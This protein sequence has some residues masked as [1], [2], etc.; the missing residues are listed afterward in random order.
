MNKVCNKCQQEI[1]I[2]R[3]TEHYIKA[4]IDPNYKLKNI[5]YYKINNPTYNY[6]YYFD[7]IKKF[8]YDSKSN[9]IINNAINNYETNIQIRVGKKVHH[10]NL[11]NKTIESTGGYFCFF[12][13][14]DY[15]L[16]I[17]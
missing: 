16:L 15:Y 12:P 17:K 3:F 5:N 11:L 1:P 9:N 6:Y 13:N 4:H 8:E 2:Y 7:G 14:I 10:I